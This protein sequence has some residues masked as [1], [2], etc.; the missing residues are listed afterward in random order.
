MMNNNISVGMNNFLAPQRIH[1]NKLIDCYLLLSDYEEGMYNPLFK[2]MSDVVIEYITD[3]LKIMGY[4]IEIVEQLLDILKSKGPDSLEAISI[5]KQIDALNGEFCK[6][7]KPHPNDNFQQFI[8]YMNQRHQINSNIN[9]PYQNKINN[10][11]I[12][13]IIN[14][15][16]INS[17]MILVQNALVNQNNIMINQN[18]KSA[19]SY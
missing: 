7:C 17:D 15:G 18:Q 1:W 10:N 11:N 5:M 12:N 2:V 13:I 9:N 16:M 8:N 4:N 6:K 14:N 3:M 19:Y